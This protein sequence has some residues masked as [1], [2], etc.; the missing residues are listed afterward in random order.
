MTNVIIRKDY[1]ERVLVYFFLFTGY[2]N[3]VLRLSDESDFTLFRILLPIGFA[4]FFWQYSKSAILCASAIF[5]FFIYGLFTSLFLSR[6]SGFSVVHLLHYTTLIFLLFFTSSLIRRFGIL[7]VF[8]HLRSIYVL[9]IFLAAVQLLTAFEFPNT[10]YRGTLNIFFGVD[11]D[12]AAALAVMIPALLMDRLHP[13]SSK[14]LA[15]AGTAIIAYNGSRIALIALVLFVIFILLNKYS[16]LG[17]IFSSLG[18]VILFFVFRDY[19]LGG[20][21]LEK[22]LLEPFQHIF[23]LTPSGMHGSIYYRTDALIF[24]IKELISTL[25]F[26]IGPGNATRMFELPEYTLEGAQSMHNFV[27]QTIVEFG[28]LM[29]ALILLFIKSLFSERRSRVM[30]VYVV[31]VALASLSQSEGLFS[32]YYFFVAGLCCF[33]YLSIDSRSQ[34]ISKA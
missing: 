24:G 25:G 34:I 11:N 15:G 2:C 18:V 4:Y 6:F 17:W 3:T 23:T 16:Y 1:L 33:R 27:A 30:T 12:F 21:S 31:T 26:G 22:L 10:T 28:W 29:I 32:N 5:S 7:S 9:M 14:I 20:D 8:A 19:R 13:F